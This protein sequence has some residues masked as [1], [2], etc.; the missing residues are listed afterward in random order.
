VIGKVTKDTVKWMSDMEQKNLSY[1]DLFIIEDV[2]FIDIDKNKPFDIE[3]TMHQFYF[4]IL[5]ESP[6]SLSSKLDVTKINKYQSFINL[7]PNQ[8]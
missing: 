1:N 5:F 3:N 2:G 8:L 7:S 4:Y 6:T